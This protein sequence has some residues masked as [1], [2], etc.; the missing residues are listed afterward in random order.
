[1]CMLLWRFTKTVLISKLIT[2]VNFLKND[3]HEIEI[4]HIYTHILKYYKKSGSMVPARFLALI[5]GPNLTR[6]E[7]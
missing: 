1:M 6:V 5:Q 4:P 2:R 3:D 7:A